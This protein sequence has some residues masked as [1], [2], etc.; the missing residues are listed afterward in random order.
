MPTSPRP[1]GRTVIIERVTWSKPVAEP[2]MFD[3]Y[4]DRAAWWAKLRRAHAHRK[5]LEKLVDEFEA[6]EPYTLTPDYG[7]S[8]RREA[9]AEISTVIGDVLHN[10][11]SALDSLAHQLAVWSKGQTLTE[12][13]ELRTSFPWCKYSSEYDRL[14]RRVGLYA[15]EAQNAM[16]V[17]QPFYWAEMDNEPDPQWQQHYEDEEN[18]GWSLI[19][20]LSQLNNIDKHRRLTVLRVGVFRLF[21]VGGEAGRPDMWFRYEPSIDDPRLGSLSDAD[22]RNIKWLFALE[23]ADDPILKTEAGKG[24]PQ[25]CREL[26]KDFA[27]E[28]NVTAWEV[29]SRYYNELNR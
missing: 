10:L 20:R 19:H 15:P 28:V 22:A 2:W 6:S 25:D 8:V 7:L 16:R 27:D 21:R 13:E 11:R 29:L 12:D 23:L 4:D 24:E 1:N 17:V 14:M 26:L 3:M 5:T 9:P 18:F